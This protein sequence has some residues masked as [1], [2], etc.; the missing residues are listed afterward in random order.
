VTEA[1]IVVVCVVTHPVFMELKL[2]Q[3]KCG[4]QRL[5]VW[6]VV[7]LWWV[8]NSEYFKGLGCLILHGQAVQKSDLE[9][10]GTKILRNLTNYVCID[11]LSSGYFPGV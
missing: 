3:Y 5:G 11:E 1:H 6:D 2:T 10:E 7:L 9:D 8:K 4:F